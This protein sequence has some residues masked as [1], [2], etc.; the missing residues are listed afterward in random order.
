MQD[1]DRVQY[2]G[3]APTTADGLLKINVERAVLDVLTG[4]VQEGFLRI[5]QIGMDVHDIDDRLKHVASLTKTA[6]KFDRV[7]VTQYQQL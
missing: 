2:Q 3:A 6:G 5:K 7:I 4:I 1:D